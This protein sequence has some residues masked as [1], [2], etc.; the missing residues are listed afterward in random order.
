LKMILIFNIMTRENFYKTIKGTLYAVL[1]IS[2][3]S[4]DDFTDLSLFLC[5]G[6]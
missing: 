2:L 5:A 4:H 6:R 1:K 3:A